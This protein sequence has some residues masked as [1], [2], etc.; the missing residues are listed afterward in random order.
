MLQPHVSFLAY[1]A[2]AT[3]NNHIF[4]FN[5]ERKKS[6]DSICSQPLSLLS[7]HLVIDRSCC[8]VV[9]VI[10]FLIS[11]EQSESGK[12]QQQQHYSHHTQKDLN[13]F[14]GDIK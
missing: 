6:H 1:K 8:R 13:A 11:W 12:H 3:M 14:E 2:L 7:P 4:L 10:R 5:A 9:V